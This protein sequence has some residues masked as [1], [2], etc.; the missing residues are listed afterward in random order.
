MTLNQKICILLFTGI[1]VILSQVSAYLFYRIK[2]DKVLY[3]FIVT[4]LVLILWLYFGMNEKMSSN[5]NQL[6]FNAR[7]SLIP[8]MLT[9]AVW[10]IFTL[11]YINKFPQK[12]RRW[13]LLIL[14]PTLLCMWPLFTQKY[15][16]L[17]IVAKTIGGASKTVWGPLMIMSLLVSY[18]YIFV[19]LFLLFVAF[20]KKIS[21][22]LM[23]FLLLIC[24]MLPVIV[25]LGTF[26]N[27]IPSPGFDITPVTYSIIS[28][29][30]AYYILKYRLMDVIP[31]ASYHLFTVIDDPV[32]ILDQD[33]NILKPNAAFTQFMATFEPY[34]TYTHLEDVYDLLANHLVEDHQIKSY[35]Q[36]AITNHHNIHGK[37]IRLVGASG[38]QFYAFDWLSLSKRNKPIGYLLVLKDITK[39]KKTT[40]LEERIKVSNDLSSNLSTSMYTIMNGLE[41]AIQNM[42]L[43]PDLNTTLT[44]VYEQS[45]HAIL[46]L[47]DIINDLKPV[48]LSDNGLMFELRNLFSRLHALGIGVDFSHNDLESFQDL[49]EIEHDIYQVCKEAI[50]DA[51]KN[52]HAKN[53]DII[54]KHSKHTVKLYINDDGFSDLKLPQRKMLN[55]LAS[56]I[57]SKGGIIKYNSD[58]GIGFTLNVTWDKLRVNQKNHVS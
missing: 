2:K 4:Q 52:G 44:T 47:N 54:L 56:D 16:H 15:I 45:K 39:I 37:I 12:T 25:A 27:I 18:A 58:N 49:K 57:Q 13:I 35:C 17:I 41:L 23:K 8:I 1:I 24:M 22:L 33:L 7:L 48:N 29:V 14:T 38:N 46:E 6:I 42:T 21:N 28:L 50:S 26:F 43:K 53:F 10:L 36:E 55:P 30:S 11:F 3:S 51:F 31:Q 19:S 34:A 9:G 20:S 5:I 40:A 32:L